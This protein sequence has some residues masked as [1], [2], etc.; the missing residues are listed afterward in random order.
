M[1][2]RQFAASYYKQ[3]CTAAPDALQPKVA[4]A[5]LKIRDG[6][7]LEASADLDALG[8]I[9][10]GSMLMVQQN[11][12]AALTDFRDRRL[13]FSDTGANHLAY[14]KLLLRAGRNAESLQPLE[15]ALELDGGN[16]VPWNLLG[17]LSRELGNYARAREAFTKSL[18]L[19]PDQ[20]RTEEALRTIDELAKAAQAPALPQ[21]DAP[22]EP[23]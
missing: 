7:I 5:A 2:L 6:L 22:K 23:Q 8:T 10:P 9:P 1:G 19:N 12:G 3:A 14:T 20:P 13:W 16:F 18:E 15:R 11:L 4:L 17:S 21:L